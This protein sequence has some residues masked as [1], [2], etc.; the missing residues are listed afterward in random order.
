M[1][2]LEIVCTNGTCQDSSLSKSLA[3]ESKFK[4]VKMV[5]YFILDQMNNEWEKIEC[6]IKKENNKVELIWH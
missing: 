6:Q 5:R 3:E 2:H 4:N 1:S